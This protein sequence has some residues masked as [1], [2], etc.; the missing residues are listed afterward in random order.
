MLSAPTLPTQL[1]R[2]WMT[3]FPGSLRVEIHPAVAMTTSLEPS[4]LPPVSHP[5]LRVCVR[6]RV[7]ACACVCVRVCVCVCA[8]VFRTGLLSFSSSVYIQSHTP[9]VF[10][11]QDLFC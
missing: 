3:I 2:G 6:V 4:V 5:A 8:L 10:C 7:C 1:A 9:L 11:N